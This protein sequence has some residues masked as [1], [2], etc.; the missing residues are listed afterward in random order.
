MVRAKVRDEFFGEMLLQEHGN[1]LQ[2]RIAFFDAVG[3][4]KEMKICDIEE[5]GA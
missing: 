2:A 3:G 4:I 5:Y 1:V